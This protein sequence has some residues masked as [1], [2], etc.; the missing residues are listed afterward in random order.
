MMK[1]RELRVST[2]F[3]IR[4]QSVDDLVVAYSTNLS[5]GGLFLR[6]NRLLEKGSTLDL[7][8]H[9]PDG[10]EDL[11]VPCT[12]VYVRQGKDVKAEGM[13]LKFIDPD[14]CVKKRLE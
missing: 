13:G 3:A 2:R 14:D 4:F 7:V 8:M 9:L 12:V 11:L 1:P 10:E 6:T 5:R